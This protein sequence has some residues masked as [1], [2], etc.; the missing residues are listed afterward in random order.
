MEIVLLCVCKEETTGID[1]A[2]F[3]WTGGEEREEERAEL[4][5]DLY[6]HG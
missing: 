5:G 6:L 1:S 4:S 3:S 2:K